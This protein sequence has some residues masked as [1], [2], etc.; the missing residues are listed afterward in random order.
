MT[1][2]SITVVLL[3][4]SRGEA[5]PVAMAAGVP[6]KALAAVDGEPL[7][8]H[9]VTTLRRMEEVRRIILVC[10]RPLLLRTV[11]AVRRAEAAGV[12]SVAEPGSSPSRSVLGVLD[13]RDAEPPV[14]VVTADAPLLTAEMIRRFLASVPEDADVAA[15]VTP[16]AGVRARFPE[17]RRTFLRF[18]DGDV[19]GCNLFLLKT[20][21]ARG[22]VAFWRRVEDQ[23]K[24]PW[25]LA[26]RLGP[27]AVVGYLLGRLTLAGA[28]RHVS[29]KS[30]ARAAVV[31]IPFPEAAV[32][33]DRPADLAVVERVLAERR[34]EAPAP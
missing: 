20:P 14:L 6:H 27:G 7:V 33:V 9:V 15:A 10:D 30:G 8:G 32:D 21:A 29:R 25:A 28:A 2:P 19:S 23:R 34:R 24:R 26:A 12:L 11:E 4:A 17:S 5:D 31:P 18:R 22:A 1:A 13:R 3:A 16:C